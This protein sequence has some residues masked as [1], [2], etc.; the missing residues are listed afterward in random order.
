VTPARPAKRTRSSQSTS[1]D[2]LAD[3]RRRRDP[4]VTPEPVP[5][6]A[7]KARRGSGKPD[8]A[9]PIFVI[10]EHHARALHWDFRLERD[11]VLV[12]WAIPKGLPLDKKTNH[13]AVHTEDH[14]LE[15]AS[16]GGTIPRGEYGGGQVTVWDHGTYDELKW[17]DREVMVVLHGQRV[18]G[19]Y[20]LFATDG[21]PRAATKGKAA[22]TGT[23]RTRAAAT[24]GRSWM[25]HRMD[26]APQ[27]YEPPPRELRPMLATPGLLPRDDEAWVYEFKWDGIRA[28][29]YVDGGRI[30]IESRNGNDLTHSFPELRAL[31]EQLGSRQVVL[32]GE[33][34]AFDEAGRP[35]FQ[36]LQPRIHASD[37]AKARRLAAEQPIVY[38]LFDLLYVDGALCI[39]ETYADRRRRLEDLGLVTEKTEHWTLS[40]RF[41][42]P[43]ADVVQA[44]ETQ[45]LEGVLA[46]RLDSIYLPG[47]RS[48]SWLKIKNVRT[49]EVIVGGWTPGEGNRQGRLGSLLLGVPS[50]HGLQYIGQVGTGFTVPILEDLAE[51]LDHRRSEVNPFV[52]P[53]PSRYEKVARWVEPTLVGEVSFSE[54]TKDGRLRQ[55]SW[56]GLRDDKSP[57]EVRRE[58]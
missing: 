47:K 36:L 7:P 31:G 6:S 58:S 33:I 37:A 16:F 57:G 51:K 42:G 30:R 26:D 46:K 20:V 14:P 12:S 54:W 55:P 24:R 50:P 19:T 56:R 1:G 11:G 29:S 52:T 53:V 45:G 2:K 32:D 25:V 48:P 5:T 41:S 13:L 9:L 21:P 3:Y 35:R 18:E 10:Q 38:V 40:P 34:V 23:A 43:G 49:Q 15:Y 27:G 28:V 39:A 8:P 44:S 17:S 4:S 22:K